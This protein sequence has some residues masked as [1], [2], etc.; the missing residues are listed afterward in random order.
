MKVW[1]RSMAPLVLASLMIM[2]LVSACGNNNNGGNTANGE[3]TPAPANNANKD[4]NAAATNDAN[5]PANEP[6]KAEEPPAELTYYYIVYEMPADQQAVEDAINAYIK[7]KIN[8]TIK[9]KP[10]MEAGYKDKIN[11]MLAANES[12]DL[13][14]TSNWGGGDYDN[15][16][17]KGA[18]LPLDDLIANTPALKDA[19]PQVAWDDTRVDGKIYGMPNMQIAAKAEGFAIQKRFIDKYN[20]DVNSI[21]TQMD[22]E[23]VLKTI[24]E[25]EPDIIPIANTSNMFDF[26]R[27]YG[28]ASQGY[29]IGDPEYKIVDTIDKPEYKTFLDMVRRWYTSGYIYKDA[30]TMKDDQMVALLNTGKV[31]VEW[32]TTMKPGG[33]AD[34]KKRFGNNDVVY[35]RVSEPEF[36]GVRATMNSISRT[37]K[38]PEKAL[39]FLQLTATDPELFNLI[40]FGIKDKHYTMIGDNTIK[41]NQD[42]G[43]KGDQGWVFGNVLIGYLKEGQAPDTWERTKQLNETAK[44]PEVT[45]FNFNIEPYKTESVNI[46][47]VSEQYG[48]ALN[49]GSVDP[50]KVLPKYQ[51]ALKK[52]GIEKQT[53]ENQKQLDEWLKA[54]GKK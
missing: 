40:T 49:T 42:G 34:D 12:F 9:L 18:L 41:I 50:A 26:G 8:A 52:A 17:A 2:L 39:E 38:N 5:E 23:P 51:A 14:W 16:V 15:K 4:A 47:A 48:K 33:E 25:N 27:Q 44:R 21:K 31:A 10:V 19:I 37:S 43:Y 20:I 46:F 24:H 36:T 6:A 7:P 11:T 28:Y 35:V 1:K 22:I 29:K 32:N 54:N 53:A 45:G 13:L 30:A 3:N